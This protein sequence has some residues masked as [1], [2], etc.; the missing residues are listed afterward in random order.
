VTVTDQTQIICF[1]LGQQHQIRGGHSS[2]Y[3]W[4]ST[5][6]ADRNLN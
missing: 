1:V 2:F 5:L 6:P 3:L 4:I